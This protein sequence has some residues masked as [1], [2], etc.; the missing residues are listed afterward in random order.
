MVPETLSVYQ[1]G[2]WF[3]CL[4][5]SLKGG[6]SSLPSRGRRGLARSRQEFL[7]IVVE[8]DRLP[9]ALSVHCNDGASIDGQYVNSLLNFCSRVSQD[10]LHDSGPESII[11][12]ALGVLACKPLREVPFRRTAPV[13]RLT[14]DEQSWPSCK[15]ITV[16]GTDPG[17]E[18]TQL[19]LTQLE[20]THAFTPIV[21]LK[22]FCPIRLRTTL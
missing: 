12:L 17:L 16:V 3:E 14:Q 19:K 4:K 22:R 20:L 21:I 9:E 6:A 2:L 15:T 8:G 18:L 5:H 7:N 11:P 10:R 13:V 1:K